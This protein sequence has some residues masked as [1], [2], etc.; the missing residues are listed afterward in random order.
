MKDSTSSLWQ[1]LKVSLPVFVIIVNKST[2]YY[3]FNYLPEVQKFY[4]SIIIHRD[5]FKYCNFVIYQLYIN[6]INVMQKSR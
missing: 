5:L 2:R 3:R 1:S 4:K 6:L